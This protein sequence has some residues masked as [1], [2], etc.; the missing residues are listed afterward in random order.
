MLQARDCK[1]P[2]VKILR[3]GGGGGWGWGWEGA[4]TAG[5]A[6]T[7]AAAHSNLYYG[8]KTLLTPIPSSP[9]ATCAVSMLAAWRIN[10][11]HNFTV[12]WMTLKWH[13]NKS[14]NSFSEAIYAVQLGLPQGCC[15]MGCHIDDLKYL[16]HIQ[17][18]SIDYILLLLYTNYITPGRE[19]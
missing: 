6:L 12:K 9:T 18:I 10:K 15:S 3:G 11:I 1:R 17:A 16:I 7:L 8:K 19:N 14:D 2:N 13:D 5:Q 4:N